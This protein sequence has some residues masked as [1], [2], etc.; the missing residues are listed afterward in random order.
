MPSLPNPTR[1]D[2]VHAVMQRLAAERGLSAFTLRAIAADVGIAPSTLVAQFTHRRR[3][4]TWFGVVSGS[5]RLA[6]WDRALDRRGLA[7]LLPHDRDDLEAEAA[8]A[9]VVEMGRTDEV[10]GGTVLLREEEERTLIAHVLSE[11][12]PSPVR[13]WRQDSDEVVALAALLVGLRG[14]MVRGQDPMP[15]ADA[16]RLLRLGQARLCGTPLRE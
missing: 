11:E 2:A 10:V 3:L 16:L 9:A 4:V 15:L 1:P 13:R 7:A 6:R 14:A 5:R 12:E 8:W